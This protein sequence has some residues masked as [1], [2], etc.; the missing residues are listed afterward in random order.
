MVIWFRPEPS[1]REQFFSLS[2]YMTPLASQ[3]GTSPQG[4]IRVEKEQSY[5]LIQWKLCNNDSK[6]LTVLELNLKNLE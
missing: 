3:K 4:L 5:A 2:L 6:P 1:N